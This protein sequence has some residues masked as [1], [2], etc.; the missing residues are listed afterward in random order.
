MP[1]HQAGKNPQKQLIESQSDQADE[2][3]HREFRHPVLH[4][5]GFKYPENTERIICGQPGQKRNRGGK[6]VGDPCIFGQK[7][8]QAEIHHVRN[9]AHYPISKQLDVNPVCLFLQNC[10]NQR[11][12]LHL[13]VV[14]DSQASRR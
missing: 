12:H 10:G 3:E 13:M 11:I 7:K 5:A 9:S 8:Q 6:E 1:A 4:G 2:R 14:N